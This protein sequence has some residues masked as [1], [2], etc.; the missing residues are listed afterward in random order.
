M[1]Y[2]KSTSTRRTT[3]SRGGM[4]IVRRHARVRGARH[5]GRQGSDLDE[6]LLRPLPPDARI[7]SGVFSYTPRFRH[8]RRSD[9][10][11]A[12][13]RIDAHS[14]DNRH[15]WERSRRRRRSYRRLRLRTS[16]SD[17]P[18]TPQPPFRR[19]LS[20]SASRHVTFMQYYICIRKP[21]RR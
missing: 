13:R 11:T 6:E 14:A 4:T 10:R 20:H 9:R 8:V 21:K 15:E 2:G 3:A 7:I 18:D 12:T 17:R 16:S 1:N 5:A 19:S